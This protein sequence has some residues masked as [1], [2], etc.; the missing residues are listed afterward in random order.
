MHY[1]W[2][3]APKGTNKNRL[4]NNK[5]KD[6]HMRSTIKTGII[7]FLLAAIFSWN[8][9]ITQANAQES[10][11]ES[12]LKV[13][14]YPALVPDSGVCN[15]FSDR[16]S[17]FDFLFYYE[18]DKPIKDL[19]QKT[20]T[21]DLPKGIAVRSVALMAG[22]RKSGGKFYEFK[23]EK[24][25]R[26]DQ[27]YTRYW[28]PL[29]PV[30]NNKIVPRLGGIEGGI[31]YNHA[32]IFVEPRV[33]APES[34][35]AYWSVKE[36]AKNKEL[37]GSFKVKLFSSPY[38]IEK[39]KRLTMRAG[40]WGDTSLYADTIELSSIV[41]LFKL[42]G[43]SEVPAIL[44][45]KLDEAG[46]PDLWSKA[47]FKFYDGKI[48]GVLN[49]Y[50]LAQRTQSPDDKDYLKGL[51]GKISKGGDWHKHHG[52]LFCPICASTPGRL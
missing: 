43:I 30:A 21:L 15:I 7:S 17:R 9:S 24:I 50:S 37:K 36:E 38:D 2:N 45:G 12:Q 28:L 29:P 47:G 16:I 11:Q 48:W 42:L 51:D 25:K 40:S 49:A 39:P 26:G 41:Q 35:D 34:F 19:N 14:I 6:K 44:K 5:I 22:W 1:E 23:Q 20:F 27:E 10:K 33:A 4:R 13:Y 32:K 8:I 3:N 46:R 31:C 52:R 18:G